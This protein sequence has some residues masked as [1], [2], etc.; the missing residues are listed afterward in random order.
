MEADKNPMPTMELFPRLASVGRFV[1]RT[2]TP[3]PAEADVS[4]STHI[5][6]PAEAQE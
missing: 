4:L 2:L 6:Q 3:F 1:L 5:R